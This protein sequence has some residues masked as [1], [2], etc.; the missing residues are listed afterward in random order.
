MIWIISSSD[1]EPNNDHSSRISFVPTFLYT[2]YP[3]LIFSSRS[4][5]LHGMTQRVYTYCNVWSQVDLV[6][7]KDRL[8]ILCIVKIS[9]LLKLAN[10]SVHF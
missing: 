2:N 5:L 9:A 4:H 1:G 6:T 3:S 10:Y 8:N 7:E